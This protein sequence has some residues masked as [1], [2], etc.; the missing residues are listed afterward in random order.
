LEREQGGCL[1][2]VLAVMKDYVRE[3]RHTPPGIEPCDCGTPPIRAL[4]AVLEE[5][6]VGTLE[7]MK[8]VNQELGKPLIGKRLVW[9]DCSQLWKRCT[10][11]E[12]HISASERAEL[13]Q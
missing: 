3:E 11:S 2:S 4:L 9:C 10:L 7:L 6:V 8:E 12:G 1:E 13:L 5:Q